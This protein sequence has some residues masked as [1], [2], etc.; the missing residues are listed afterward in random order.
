M[1]DEWSQAALNILAEAP[2]GDNSLRPSVTNE[3]GRVFAILCFRILNITL[4]PR[5][6]SEHPLYDQRDDRSIG[7]QFGV[8]WSWLSKIGSTETRKGKE[9]FDDIRLVQFQ[10]SSSNPVATTI[11]HVKASR[12][13]S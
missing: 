13:V 12:R 2:N 8:L 10:R 3:L 7:K 11:T 9:A 4:H 6:P 5:K 1:D